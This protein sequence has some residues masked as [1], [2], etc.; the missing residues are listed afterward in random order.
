[1]II[2]E[3][4]R[5]KQIR[6]QSI[7]KSHKKKNESYKQLRISIEF[8][9]NQTIHAEKNRTFRDAKSYHAKIR[10]CRHCI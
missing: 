8:S 7:R 9:P 2:L 4:L 3:K 1:M 5:R 10:S 6:G